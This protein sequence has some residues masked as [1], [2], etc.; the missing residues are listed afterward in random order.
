[1]HPRE[2]ALVGPECQCKISSLSSET[3]LE[4]ILVALAV[5]VVLAEAHVAA[6]V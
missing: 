6:V 4:D 5:S 1:M 3:S 2:V